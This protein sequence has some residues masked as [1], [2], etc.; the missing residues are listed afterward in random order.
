MN[1]LCHVYLYQI[2]HRRLNQQRRQQSKFLF[3]PAVS[4]SVCADVGLFRVAV[5]FVCCY[6]PVWFCHFS[7]VCVKALAPVNQRVQITNRAQNSVFLYFS[8][9]KSP[10]ENLQ[11]QKFKLNLTWAGLI[12]LLFRFVILQPSLDYLC[13]LVILLIH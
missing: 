5:P 8:T 6:W 10:L 7:G 9:L 4:E 1:V 12:Y 13:D 11:P 3:L 2:P